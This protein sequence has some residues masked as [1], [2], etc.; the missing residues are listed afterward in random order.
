MKNLDTTIY[1]AG[2]T[3]M[4]GS[5]ILR[6]LHEMGYRNLI[7]R[8]REEL[9]LRRQT[10]VD[11]FFQDQRPDVVI[12]AAGLVGGIL[13][14]ST[15]PAEFIYDNMCI[16]L[17]IVESVRK[18]DSS[19]LL[20]LSSNCIYPRNS[21][22]PMKESYLCDG[23]MEDTNVWYGTAKYAGIRVCEA[24]RKQYGIDLISAIPASVYGHGDNFDPAQSHVIP[25]L[26]HKIYEANRRGL[27]ICQIWGSGR[28][29]R[30]FIHSDDLG[31]AVVFLLKNYSEDEPIN[32]GVGNDITVL[33]VAHMIRDIIAPSLEFSCDSSMPDGV[34]QK[35]LD[36]SKIE[37]LG[38]SP[39][40]SFTD[41]LTDT[42][43]WYVSR[44]K[45][46]EHIRGLYHI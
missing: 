36:S 11:E 21:P 16:N 42:V 23:K 1:V 34:H 14:N 41:G 7:T 35:M 26:I 44:R 13:A 39:K 12:I 4:V 43:E 6:Q 10:D 29:R 24:Y 15:R 32:I 5:A 22:Q 2:H 20:Y 28:S 30:E 8:G 45:S 33:E 3:G 9:D 38:W 31:S 18:Y 46:G 25:A 27:E 19:K 17:N 37:K 40:K